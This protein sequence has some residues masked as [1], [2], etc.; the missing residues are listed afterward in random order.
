MLIRH[1]RA[2]DSRPGVPDR[3][4][5]LTREGAARF[6]ATA[7]GLARLLQRPAVLLTS[8]MLRARQTAALCSA[9]WGSIEPTPEP[10]LASGS[11]DEVLEALE[12]RPHDASVVLV[13]H[14]PTMSML[15]TELLGGRAE[16]IRFGVGTAALVEM[17]SLA[18][19][20]AR[21]VWFL[22]AEVTEALGTH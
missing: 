1:A 5:A 19:R 17:D 3:D 13:G 14:E 10:A 11:V 21:L 18:T 16:A 22:P 6:E 9:T 7:R 12:A 8:P 2:E 15:L 4:R 20:T